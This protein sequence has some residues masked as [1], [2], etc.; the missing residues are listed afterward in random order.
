MKHHAYAT[1]IAT[2]WKRPN[3][4]SPKLRKKCKFPP[5]DGQEV[6]PLPAY[7]FVEAVNASPL[8]NTWRPCREGFNISAAFAG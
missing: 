1:Q 6:Q 3:R 7:D 4:L 2:Q 8:V 5:P